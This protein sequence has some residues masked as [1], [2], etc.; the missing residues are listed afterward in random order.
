[1]GS[2]PQF[3]RQRMLDD[4]RMRKFGEKTQLDYVRPVGNFME[5]VNRSNCR[6]NCACSISGSRPTVQISSTQA[7]QRS[8][9]DE[10][11]QHY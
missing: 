11:P 10:I 2:R 9:C 3:R 7:E 1:M 5:Y 8:L 6:S 4:M